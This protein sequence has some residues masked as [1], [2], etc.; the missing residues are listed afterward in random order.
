[1]FHDGAKQAGLRV[2]EGRDVSVTT[3]QLKGSHGFENTANRFTGSLEYRRIHQT[4]G[5]QRFN[6]FFW[7]AIF[8]PRIVEVWVYLV[9]ECGAQFVQHGFLSRGQAF[10]K[11]V[12]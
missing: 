7:Q 2:E 12:D 11:T 10:R 8:V 9:G 3:S 4:Q 6:N 5:L 1:L